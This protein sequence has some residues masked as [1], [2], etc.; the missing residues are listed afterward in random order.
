MGTGPRVQF[1]LRC[2]GLHRRL[3]LLPDALALSPAVHRPLGLGPAG[4]HPA[5][6]AGLRLPLPLPPGQF[7]L[8]RLQLAEGAPGRPLRPADQPAALPQ[9]VEVVQLIRDRRQALGL[10]PLVDVGQATAQTVAAVPRHLLQG[11][12]AAEL[13]LPGRPGQRAVQ[14]S[15]RHPAQALRFDHHQHR[16]ADIDLVGQ[17]LPHQRARLLVHDLEQGRRTPPGGLRPPPQRGLAR[18]LAG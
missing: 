5:G 14:P 9:Q 16:L 3:H 4:P 8:G 6:P 15:S 13:L 17:G 10:P 2:K 11:R 1:P 12:Q 7:R 18:S